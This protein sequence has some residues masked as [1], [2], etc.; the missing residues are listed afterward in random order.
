MALARVIAPR[1]EFNISG[2]LAEQFRQHERITEA[3][4]GALD[5]AKLQRLLI[6]VD[7]NFAP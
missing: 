6:D 1:A 7:M 3:A 4:I 2:D 5:G